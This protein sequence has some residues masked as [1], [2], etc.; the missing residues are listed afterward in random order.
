MEYTA[1]IE[2]GEDG[3]YFAKCEQLP[4]AMT[5]GRTIEEAEENLKDAIK[6]VLEYEKEK[7]LKSMKGRKFI[8]RTIAMP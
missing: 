8:R 7:I 3:W 6:L 1:I 5:Q 2:K 4:A